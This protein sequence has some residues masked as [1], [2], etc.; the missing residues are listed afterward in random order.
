MKEI[1]RRGFLKGSIA[2]TTGLILVPSLIVPD[3]SSAQQSPSEP[4]RGDAWEYA[5]GLAKRAMPL[6]K[7]NFH[8][9][10]GV[11]FKYDDFLIIYRTNKEGTSVSVNREGHQSIICQSNRRTNTRILGWDGR[12]VTKLTKGRIEMKDLLL[13]SS[14]HITYAIERTYA[15]TTDGRGELE[16]LRYVIE[17]AY[18]WQGVAQYYNWAGDQMMKAGDYLLFQNL[19]DTFGDIEKITGR[20]V[21][22]KIDFNTTAWRL[23]DQSNLQGFTEALEQKFG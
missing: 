2:A 12:Q 6:V 22:K 1:S 13:P 16:S 9:F 14:R 15:Q 17:P 18:G 8:E 3:H 11:P 20:K 23:V 7:A 5:N 4:S 21:P 10:R 19:P